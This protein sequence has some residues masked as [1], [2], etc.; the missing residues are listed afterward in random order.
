MSCYLHHASRTI[1]KFASERWIPRGN[2]IFSSFQLVF[3]A[4][5]E[6]STP[7]PANTSSPLWNQT[8]LLG[9]CKNVSIMSY[10]LKKTFFLNFCFFAHHIFPP[11]SMF[12]FCVILSFSLSCYH[13]VNLSMSVCSSAANGCRVFVDMLIHYGLVLN[14]SIRYLT[15]N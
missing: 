3:P 15:E 9:A 10:P 11:T 14:Q 13:L 8:L 2:S 6:K 1:F 4:C 5:G 12:W 7:L